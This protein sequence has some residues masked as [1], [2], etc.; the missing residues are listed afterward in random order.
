MNIKQNNAKSLQVDEI[1]LY[2]AL[3]E[4]WQTERGSHEVSN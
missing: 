2:K 4:G 3:G 1:A